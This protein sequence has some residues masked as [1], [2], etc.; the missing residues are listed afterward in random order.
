[1]S[2][3]I[4]IG[5]ATAEVI[6]KQPLTME[7]ISEKLPFITN[8]KLIIVNPLEERSKITSELKNK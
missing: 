6:N 3:P 5:G 1:M 4:I 8:A 2:A 7:E